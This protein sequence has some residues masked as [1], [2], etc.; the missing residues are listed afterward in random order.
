MTEKEL[1]NSIRNLLEHLRHVGN[2]GHNVIDELVY[3]AEQDM[4]E[5]ERL[6]EE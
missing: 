6:L 4:K 3:C 2:K 5:A 1:K